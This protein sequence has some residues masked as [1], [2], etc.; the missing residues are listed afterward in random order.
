[1]SAA[2]VVFGTR[3]VH[4]FGLGRVFGWAI[5]ASFD[6]VEVM[7]DDRWDTHRP[8]PPERLAQRHGLYLSWPC[9]LPSTRVPGGWRWR[10]GSSSA[11]LARKISCPLVVGHPPGRPLTRWMVGPL[12]NSW[13]EGVTVAV[14]NMPANPPDVFRIRR[15][16][17]HPPEHPKDV[18]Q[19]TLDTSH[20]GAS[21]VDLMAAHAAL[22][23]QLRHFYLSD[24]TRVAGKDEHGTPGRGEPT[25]SANPWRFG[26]GCV[27]RR[28]QPRA[29]NPGLWARRTGTLSWSAWAPR[30]GLRGKGWGH[31]GRNLLISSRKTV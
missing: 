19:V 6:G 7:M 8:A 2:P 23:G 18:G 14:E 11:R 13:A 10:R 5:E 26:R 24:S 9:T 1:M 20:V 31:G 25:A 28:G 30:S 21:R 16:S 22:A 3:S 15:T 27:P 29:E 17:C 12:A 4:P